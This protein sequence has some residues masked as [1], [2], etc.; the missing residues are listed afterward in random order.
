LAFILLWG[1]NVIDATVDA[2]LKTFDVSPD[3]SFKIKAGYSEIGETHG[4][5]LVLFRK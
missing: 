4:L 1:L 2:H 5:S 3:L